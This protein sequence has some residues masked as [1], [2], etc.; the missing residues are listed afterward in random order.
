M[1]PPYGITY[2]DRPTG[3]C[4]DGRMII[5]F[6]GLGLPFLP[7]YLRH[8]NI[9]DFKQGVA[10]GVAGATAIDVPFFTSIGLT[11]TSNHSLRVQIGCFKDLLPALC[12]SPSCK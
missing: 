9:Q 4:S 3:R 8:T 5:D 6:I 7:A 12:G 2:F 10:F 1:K 11:T